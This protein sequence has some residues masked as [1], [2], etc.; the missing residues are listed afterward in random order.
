MWVHLGRNGPQK[1]RAALPFHC[2]RCDR[3][4][5]ILY[6]HR[7]RFRLLSMMIILLLLQA[8]SLLALEQLD[9][10][11]FLPGDISPEELSKIMSID[12]VEDRVV[13]GSILDRDLG[14]LQRLGLDFSILP[15]TKASELQ[16][17]SD[18]WEEASE[19]AWDCYPTYPQYVALMQRLAQHYPAVCRLQSLG[20]S[21]NL[22]RPHE[23]LALKITDHPDEEEDEPEVFLTSTMHGDELGG[24]VLLLRLAW[25]LIVNPDED[26]EIS[27]SIA[28]TETWINP[29]ANPD[30]AYFGG[31]DSVAGSIRYLT[32]TSGQIS[33]IDPNRNFPDFFDGPFP[34]NQMWAS[35]TQAMMYFAATHSIVLSANFHSGS[36]VVNYPWD[37]SCQVH[38]DNDWFEEI[39]ATWAHDA[40]EDG[41]PGYMTDCFTS[42]CTGQ[43]CSIP[44]V[45]KGA[46][47][48][49]VAG[50][51]Q[52][53]MTSFMHGRELTVEISHQK[54]L[55]SNELEEL[56][57]S[58]RRAL[59][60]FIGQS[61]KGIHGTI[62]DAQGQP[63]SA[64]I[65]VLNHDESL[66]T[67]FTDPD[68]GDFHRM[69]LPG[70]YDLGIRSGGMDDLLIFRLVVGSAP[71][72]PELQL[73]MTGTA[74]VRPDNMHPQ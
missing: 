61:L 6:N 57:Q 70:V 33:N 19:P 27:A 44:G 72:Y 42:R 63:L 11:V 50:G 48:Y 47:W 49:S 12:R 8:G 23:I 17:C 58:Q 66:S 43:P 20:P 31:D 13:Y 29:L 21:T 74:P 52:D 14:S 45:T 18:G 16:M 10:K 40:Q 35:E 24:Y 65:E 69:L 64:R 55:P 5:V 71:P 38:P 4:R 67:V 56:W 1:T 39:S 62:R 37:G 9:L 68:R 53:W 2:P 28:A 25:N 30:G 59:I 73:Q 26:P 22:V 46:D 3:L 7:M 32:T 60:D 36:E 54:Q 41:P 15:R 51:R 34:N